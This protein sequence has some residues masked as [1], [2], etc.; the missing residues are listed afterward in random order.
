MR[1]DE[2]KTPAAPRVPLLDAARGVAL[3]AM[4]AYHLVWDLGHFA[5]I[6]EEIPWRPDFQFAGNL[7]AGAFLFIAGLSLALAARVT[8]EPRAFWRR[9]GLLIAAAAGVSAATYVAF[10]D[11]FVF[12]GILHCIALATLVAFPLLR[13][14]VGI[15]TAL[16]AVVLFLPL[17]AAG[18]AFDRPWLLW[19][20]LGTTDPVTN[21]W[22]PFF[23]FGGVLLA[24]LAAG[25]LA[26]SRELDRRLARWSGANAP[27]RALRLGGRHSLA[28]YLLHQPAVYGLLVALVWAFGAYPPTEEGRFLRACETQCQ[29]QSERAYCTRVCGCVAA[30]AKA[31]P[32]WQG[33]LANRLE[34]AESARVDEIARTCVRDSAAP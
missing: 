13:A 4:I 8:I 27:A 32:L 21:D 23:P 11:A 6:P 26:V 31:L 14:P 29:R 2:T 16:A 10:P 18:P 25:R 12:F 34:P 19:T 30:R 17:A 7:I 22:R 15:V 33:V 24:G 28:I 5:I 1:A 20:G 3:V 9:L